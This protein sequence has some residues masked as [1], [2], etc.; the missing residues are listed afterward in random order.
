MAN[1]RA[2]VMC[3][4]P[5]FRGCAEVVG[6]ILSNRWVQ[7]RLGTLTSRKVYIRT[8]EVVVCAGD[9]LEACASERAG[10][11][12]RVSRIGLEA[13]DVVKAGMVMMEGVDALQ[14][15][16]KFRVAECVEGPVKLH[17]MHARQPV[18]AVEVGG[19]A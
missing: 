6:G 9:S 14:Q 18:P 1:A 3:K 12:L 19:Q 7:S 15:L 17:R 10:S 13:A 11:D 2:A 4:V 16:G 5:R 8:K